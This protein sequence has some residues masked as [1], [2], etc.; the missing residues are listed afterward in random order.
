MRHIG[1][2]YSPE[3]VQE[4]VDAVEMNRMKS[5]KED[6]AAHNKIIEKAII[7]RKGAL[8][9]FNATCK[10]ATLNTSDTF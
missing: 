9:L 6:V 4:V 5:G 3:F 1:V 10:K 7:Y 8:S 2:V